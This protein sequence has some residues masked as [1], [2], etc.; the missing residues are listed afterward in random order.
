VIVAFEPEFSDD[1]NKKRQWTSFLKAKRVDISLGFNEVIAQV[2]VFLI[3][4]VEALG[5]END[6]SMTWVCSLGMWKAM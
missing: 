1:P 3:P 2:E 5:Q 4:I 6:F